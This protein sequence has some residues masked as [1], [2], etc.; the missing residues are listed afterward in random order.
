[1][2]ELFSRRYK[3]MY[4]RIIMV[5]R[6]PAHLGHTLG[7]KLLD[8]NEKLDGQKSFLYAAFYQTHR[9]VARLTKAAC[10]GSKKRGR[11]PRFA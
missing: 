7:L 10:R 1:M 3:I 9:Q 8:P 6:S 11:L 5:M 2:H 4:N